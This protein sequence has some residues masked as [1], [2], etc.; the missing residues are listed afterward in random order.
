MRADGPAISSCHQGRIGNQTTLPNPALTFEQLQHIPHEVEAA[1]AELRAM[2]EY[3]PTIRH[4]W[5]FPRKYFVPEIGTCLPFPNGHIWRLIEQAFH[6]P[7]S[8]NSIVN[9]QIQNIILNVKWWEL[10][11]REIIPERFDR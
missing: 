4:M 1:S 3:A 8:I 7:Q 11:R 6:M 2:I 9:A 5:N 10:A